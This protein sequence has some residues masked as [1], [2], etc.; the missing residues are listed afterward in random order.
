MWPE[1]LRTSEWESY[2]ENFPDGRDVL[3]AMKFWMD[4]LGDQE[5]HGAIRI[6]TFKYAM[7]ILHFN[8][9]ERTQTLGHHWH[10]RIRDFGLKHDPATNEFTIV[11]KHL[12]MHALSILRQSDLWH[13]G[14]GRLPWRYF[15]KRLDSGCHPSEPIDLAEFPPTPL[16]RTPQDFQ[17][18]QHAPRTYEPRA[19]RGVF[20]PAP[21][22]YNPVRNYVFKL[23]EEM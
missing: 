20:N 4:Y 17:E 18:M 1:S 14:K 12:W 10:N 6:R 15:L 13:N 23:T 2:L 19:Q 7:R 5:A 3:L 8:A 11:N 21:E 9:G 22:P 16:R